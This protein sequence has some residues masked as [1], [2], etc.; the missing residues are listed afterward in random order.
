MG[1]SDRGR[2]S[3][4]HCAQT[5]AAGWTYAFLWVVG[6]NEQAVGRCG[7]NPPPVSDV[8][9]AVETQRNCVAL[10]SLLGAHLLPLHAPQKKKECFLLFHRPPTPPTPP[11]PAAATG[12][13]SRADTCL[14]SP[15]R[16]RGRNRCAPI[17][18]S[19][20]KRRDFC[21]CA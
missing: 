17:L 13:A 11:T 5:S 3:T 6:V 19:K 9:P 12:L 16:N 14:A 7:K 2:L 10:P 20:R 18:K 4:D 8:P 1:G 15:P 21:G